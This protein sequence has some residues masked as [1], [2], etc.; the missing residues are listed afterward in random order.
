MSTGQA[1]AQ[2]ADK[3]LKR[4]M[5]YEVKHY[6]EF[7]NAGFEWPPNWDGLEDLKAKVEHLPVS[8]QER[9]WL[10]VHLVRQQDVPWAWQLQRIPM[11]VCRIICGLAAFPCQPQLK[12]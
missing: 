10:F 2:S 11:H 5:G 4:D 1:L 6:E 3:K 7:A 8:L 12:G 9:A